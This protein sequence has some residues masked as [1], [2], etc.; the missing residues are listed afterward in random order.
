MTIN[1]LHTMV[2]VELDKT[3]SLE[4][5]S[6]TQEE[7][8]YW[9]NRAINLEVKDLYDLYI[10]SGK[11][12]QVLNR[13]QDDLFPLFDT[14]TIVYASGSLPSDYLY[15][16]NVNATVNKVLEDG[17]SVT[18]KTVSCDIIN[19]VD[20]NKYITTPTNNP[21]FDNPKYIIS[22]V[23]GSNIIK[24]AFTTVL[25]NVIIYY[26]KIPTKV[27]DVTPNRDTEYTDLPEHMHYKIAS[28]TAL[29][30][31][32]NIESN[33]FQTDIELVKNEL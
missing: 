13:I 25:T 16:I 18:D 20:A 1:E 5:P 10:T 19:E 3:S 26:I 22:R 8:D 7:I 32:E 33:R 28:R 31:L 21:Y 15:L 12:K 30:M 27:E 2:K 24:D 6:F 17:T 29:L 23:F 14:A 4:L 11:S 9:I